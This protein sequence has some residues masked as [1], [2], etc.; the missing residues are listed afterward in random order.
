VYEVDEDYACMKI[1]INK[2]EYSIYRSVSSSRLNKSVG[3]DLANC[4]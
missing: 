4:S 2:K 1:S 3:V